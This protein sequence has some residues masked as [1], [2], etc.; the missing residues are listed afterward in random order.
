MRSGAGNGSDLGEARREPGDP[1][2]DFRA[3]ARVDDVQQQVGVDNILE[4]RTERF[5]QLVRE[6]LHEA[7]R[8]GDE[9]RLAAG[10]PQPARRRIE[11]RE[12]LVFDE[13]RRNGSTG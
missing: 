4:R 1:C 12:E 8:V 6:S 11:R 10:E 3:S 9:H 7:D 2:V 5:H 13:K